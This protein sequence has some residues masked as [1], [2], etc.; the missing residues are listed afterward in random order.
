MKTI[1]TF[2][3]NNYYEIIGKIDPSLFFLHLNNLLPNNS[4][5]YM[6]GTSI[7]NEL[8]ELLK[9]SQVEPKAHIQKGTIWP[10]SKKYHIPCTEEILINLTKIIKK[11]TIPEICDH[12]IA[13]KNDA[14]LINAYDAFDY[15]YISSKI[16]ESK[17]KEFGEKL[18]CTYE[19]N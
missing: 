13:Y 1:P 17:V 2:N 6:E 19:S 16:D 14:L 10:K 4:I 12:F 8:K 7:R 3:T 15:V 18:G 9:N 11:F 5:I